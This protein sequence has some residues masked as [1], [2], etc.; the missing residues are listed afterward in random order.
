MLTEVVFRDTDQQTGEHGRLKNVDPHAGQISGIRIVT[1]RTGQFER[2]EFFIG[3]RL[4]TEGDNAPLVIH[5]QYAETRC[6]LAAHGFDGDTDIRLALA[7]LLDEGTI[8]HPIQ[9]ITG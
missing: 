6:F 8:V 1:G 5:L 2:I 3:L 7:V 9:V 4:F